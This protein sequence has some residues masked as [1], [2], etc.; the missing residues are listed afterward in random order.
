MILLGLR[1]RFFEAFCHGDEALVDVINDP[2]L[3][4][5]CTLQGRR[6]GLGALEL[7]AKIG[8]VLFEIFAKPGLATASLAGD[9]AEG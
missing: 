5:N 2:A 9:E 7:I 3:L 6:A 4:I 8:I 1:G